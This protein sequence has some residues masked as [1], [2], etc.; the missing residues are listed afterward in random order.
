MSRSANGL[1]LLRSLFSAAFLL[2][3][4]VLAIAAVGLRPGVRALAERYAKEPIAVRKPLSEFDTSRLPSFAEGWTREDIPPEEIETDE[5]A[6]IR[7]TRRNIA[8]GP[9]EVVLFVTYYSDPKSKVPHTPDVCY[10]QGGAILKE[11]KNITI[12]VPGLARGR[13]VKARLL[14]F[15]QQTYN[16]AVIFCFFADGRFRH[17]REQVRW[18]IGMPGNRHVY[19]SKI[20]TAANYPKDASPDSAVELCKTLFREAVPLLISEHFPTIEQL[21]R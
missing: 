15:E 13:E 18:L 20:E 3:A 4:A 19:F 14:L 10:R 6:I 21:K 12:D 2:S 16:Q 1:R 9:K 11:M 7:L 17:S 8:Q 5:F